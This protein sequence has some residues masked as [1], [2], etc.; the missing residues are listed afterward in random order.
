MGHFYPILARFI[1]CILLIAPQLVDVID[2]PLC[3]SRSDEWA[4]SIRTT[5]SPPAIALALQRLLI[6]LPCVFRHQRLHF[7]ASDN[8]TR[9]CPNTCA[10]STRARLAAIADRIAVVA[11]GLEVHHPDLN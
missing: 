8:V 4:R 10:V 7:G 3:L 1:V 11:R 2:A 9:S 5:A 6:P